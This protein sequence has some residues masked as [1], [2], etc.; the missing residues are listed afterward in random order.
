MLAATI[1]TF[2]GVHKGHQFLLDTL[3]REAE[4]RGLQPAVIV[5]DRD[6]TNRLTT[7]EEQ[8]TLLRKYQLSI[9]NYQLS[10]IQHLTAIEFLSTFDFQLSTLLM[11]Y[12]HR[13]GADQLDYQAL[14]SQISNLKSQINI[15]PCPQGPNVSSSAIRK[16]LQDGNIELANSMLGYNY[17]LTGTVVHGKAL[18]RT[19]GF[20]TANIQPHPSKLIPKP[21]VYMA[22]THHPSPLTALVNI[23][24]TIEAFLPDYQGP[25]FYGTTLSLE[26]THRLRD[27]QHFNSLSDLQ[28]QIQQ[29][30]KRANL[31]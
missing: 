26:L 27:E 17:T 4:Q 18:G 31:I 5:I 14:K 9:V 21:G 6:S 22:V 3:C 10:D 16:A 25:E 19:I 2:D 30:L 13:F 28:A 15:I 20:P 11:G 8:N 29:D 1:G 12:N 7:P 24:D 23:N